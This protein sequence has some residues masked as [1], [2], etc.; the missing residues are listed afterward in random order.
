MN[1][2]QK[3]FLLF[4][5]V[6]LLIPSAVSLS[7]IFAHEEDVFCENFIDTHFHKKNLDCELCDLRTVSPIVFVTENLNLY[8]PQ[9]Q[10]R[11]FFSH[12]QFLSDFQ[13]LPFELRGPPF[14]P[15]HNV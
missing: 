12:Y 8:I 11:Y 9:K 7:H 14:P 6:T 5:T 4:L 15:Y 1:L 2:I 3:N 10:T 13:K